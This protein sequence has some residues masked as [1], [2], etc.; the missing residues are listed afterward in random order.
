[1]HRIL[2]GD[3]HTTFIK[4]W[5]ERLRTLGC[6][7]VTFTRLNRIRISGKRVVGLEFLDTRQNVPRSEDVDDVILAIPP[8]SIIPLLEDSVYNADP[9]LFKINHLESEAMASMSLYLDRKVENLPP[10]HI[11]LLDSRFA[12]TLIDVSQTWPGL[13]TTVLNVIASDVND[14]RGVTDECAKDKIVSEL[15]KF[16]PFLNTAVITRSFYQPHF[17]QPLVM[18]DVGVWQFRPKAETGLENLFLAGSHCRSHIDMTSMEGAAVTGLTAANALIRCRGAHSLWEIR[19]PRIISRW[20]FVILRIVGF[21]VA[22]LG[23]LW[24]SVRGN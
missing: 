15:K 8:R 21:P 6:E 24:V 2:V 11:N 10:E 19:K 13:D 18:N 23:K 1:M 9:N 14:L 5:E 17:E 3:M 4:P 20:I 22:L 7:I 16:L 12:L